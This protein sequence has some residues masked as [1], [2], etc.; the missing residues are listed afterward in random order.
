MRSL[1]LS[2]FLLLN[3][4]G[5]SL[6]KDPRYL[7][8]QA[9]ERPPILAGSEVI[10]TA[11]SFADE[12][13]L[14]KQHNK[15]GLGKAVY[16]IKTVPMRFKIK[17]PLD[18][19]WLAIELSLKQAEIK[20]TD[21]DRSQGLFY[22]AYHDAGLLDLFGKL[23]KNEANTSLYVIH[24]STENKETLVS[25]KLASKAEQTSSL[26]KSPINDQHEDN[27]ADQLIYTLFTTL[28]DDLVH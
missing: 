20:I 21:Q 10:G 4:T 22:V 11:E 27:D 12:P 2:V 9:L 16:L 24:V 3:L 6:G 8:T 1:H 26:E 23:L 15:K 13:I 14:P 28:R 7:D 25:A 5:C 18:T 19:A 17:Q